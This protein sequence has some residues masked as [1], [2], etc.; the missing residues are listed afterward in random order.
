MGRKRQRTREKV[1]FGVVPILC[2]FD[3]QFQDPTGLLSSQ[4]QK[5]QPRQVRLDRPGIIVCTMAE[6]GG[7]DRSAWWEASRRC[8]SGL[9][10]PVSVNILLSWHVVTGNHGIVFQEWIYE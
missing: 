8:N 2:V 7:W 1:I 10:I 5:T 4:Q 3:N 9:V 6:R